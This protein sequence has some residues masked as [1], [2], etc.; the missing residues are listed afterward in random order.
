MMLMIFHCLSRYPFPVQ[1]SFQS[2]DLLQW[3]QD[4]WD[5][6][7]LAVLPLCLATHAHFLSPSSHVVILGD[8][9]TAHKPIDHCD[10]GD[11]VS[12][13]PTFMQLPLRSTVQGLAL[14]LQRQEICFS[15]TCTELGGES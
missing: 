15:Q 6:W 11:L 14:L 2:T 13:L 4:C 9:N 5:E 12:K 1:A 10:P 3:S 7:G 8:I